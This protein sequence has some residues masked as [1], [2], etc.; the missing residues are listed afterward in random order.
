M[1]REREEICKKISSIKG[2]QKIGD[3]FVE[4]V[5]EVLELC[6]DVETALSK[7]HINDSEILLNELFDIPKTTFLKLI[8]PNLETGIW[9]SKSYDNGLSIYDRFYDALNKFFSSYV[10]QTVCSELKNQF[11][12][13]IFTRF[14]IGQVNIIF[15]VFFAVFCFSNHIHCD[16]ARHIKNT[17][18]HTNINKN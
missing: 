9:V 6:N 2:I 8:S 16:F 1:D 17:H 12:S 14:F 10:K 11:H 5:N 18:K 4:L 3:K 13:L 15:N 7:D